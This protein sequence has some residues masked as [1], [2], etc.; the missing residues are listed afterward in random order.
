MQKTRHEVQ[1]K[2]VREQLEKDGIQEAGRLGDRAVELGE[3]L[4][5][6]GKC[7]IMGD[8]W[9]P[10]VLISD[11]TQYLIDWELAHY[12][13]PL[14]DI[15]HLSAHLWMYGRAYDLS[16]WL[17]VHTFID[18]YLDALGEDKESLWDER[19]WDGFKVHMGCEIVMRILG[20]FSEKYLKGR[21]QEDPYRSDGL[22]IAVRLLSGEAS[23]KFE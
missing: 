8:L 21:Y 3:E 23:L 4:L 10:S 17:L 13:R 6:P 9:P 12:G 7:L 20:T 16:P 22:D 19:E 2:P 5:D 1:Y 18:H 14:Q 11:D 15:A